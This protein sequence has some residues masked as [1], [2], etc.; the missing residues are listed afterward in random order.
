MHRAQPSGLQLKFG[1][2]VERKDRGHMSRAADPLRWRELGYA[3]AG[4]LRSVG[5]D[6]GIR[7]FCGSFVPFLGRRYIPFVVHL[8][9]ISA[10]VQ[11]V[12][13]DEH[14]S[15]P[16]GQSSAHTIGVQITAV[17]PSHHACHCAYALAAETQGDR[18]H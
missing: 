14:R 7:D 6:P 13:S 10:C 17:A 5:S 1:P 9:R 11:L 16:T 12:D 4:L 3:G 8:H 2:Q 18:P 15:L